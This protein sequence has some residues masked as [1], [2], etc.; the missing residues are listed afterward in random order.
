MW[1]FPFVYMQYKWLNFC[2]SSSSWR[3]V[4][5]IS[6][7]LFNS[8]WSQN[9]TYITSILTWSNGKTHTKKETYWTWDRVGSED[10]KC[11]EISFCG[12]VFN[13]STA[14]KSPYTNAFPTF[15][16][17]PYW[18]RSALSSLDMKNRI[19]HIW[20][21]KHLLTHRKIYLGNNHE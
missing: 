6:I 18:N 4:V 13:V 11:R 5:S 10:K 7:L 14:T 3:M 2:L 20:I 9:H 21:M 16:S 17:I 19:I 12:I 1:Y 8:F 15:V